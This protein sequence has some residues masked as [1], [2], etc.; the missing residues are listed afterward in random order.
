MTTV[1]VIIIVETTCNIAGDP[2]RLVQ[3]AI[4]S[5]IEELS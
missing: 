4:G 5:V 1:S 2:F 3:T